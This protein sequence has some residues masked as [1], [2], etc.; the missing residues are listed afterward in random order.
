MEN[1]KIT[2]RG[3]ARGAGGDR[4]R[5]GAVTGREVPTGLAGF[6]LLGMRNETLRGG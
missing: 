2:Y 1:N 5:V 4:L 6:G 3:S